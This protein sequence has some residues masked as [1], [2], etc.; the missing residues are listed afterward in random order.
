[1]SQVNVPPA[2][3]SF[4]S[5]P[6]EQSSQPSFSHS[7]GISSPSSQ[8]KMP[9]SS[10]ISSIQAPTCSSI[11][12]ASCWNPLSKA[13]I[14]ENPIMKAIPAGNGGAMPHC[15][16]TVEPSM[17]RSSV[18]PTGGHSQSHIAPEATGRSS[19]KSPVPGMLSDSSTLNAS[20]LSPKSS[21]GSPSNAR[22]REYP[23]MVE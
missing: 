8:T 7:A 11:T 15:A 2:C 23:V 20:R 14:S 5:E 22:Y 16:S 1:M 3:S 6:S 18:P 17:F 21:V 10:E 13:G 4:S 19:R 12:V 9:S